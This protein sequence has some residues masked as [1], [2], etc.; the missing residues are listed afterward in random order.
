M[1]VASFNANGL[2]AAVRRGFDGWLKDRDPDIVGLQEVR[3]TVDQLPLLDGYHSSY[4]PG[5]LAGRNGVAV[6]TKDAP[7]AVRLGFG[8]QRFDPEGRYLEVDLAPSRG[9]PGLTIASLYLPKGDRPVDGP[10]AAAKHRRKIAFM[11]SLRAHLG[12]ARRA[13]RAADREFLIMGD[14]NIAHTALD[15]RNA[16]ANQRNSGFLPDEREW[17]TSIL[18]P[19]T[20]VDV[21]RRLHGEQ[22]G[23]YS[24][25]TWRGRAFDQDTGWRIDYQLATPELARAAVVGGTDR[26]PSYQA[27]MSDHSPVVVD[28]RL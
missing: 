2:R 23:P 5:A 25:W 13:A 21:V 27:R 19:R 9:R 17:F 26:E 28:Y 8:N 15:L 11:R 12:R 24:W 20:L 16:S 7:V 22:N 1:R 14:F 18:G 10:S 3:A 4:H 6:L